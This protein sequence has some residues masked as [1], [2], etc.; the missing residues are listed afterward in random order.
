MDIS[1]LSMYPADFFTVVFIKDGFAIGSLRFKKTYFELLDKIL[2]GDTE[3]NIEI[4]NPIPIIIDAQ[5]LF[6]YSTGRS[7]FEL[8]WFKTVKI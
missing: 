1:L 7:D 3:Q 5:V 6:R 2:S 8:S 4:E